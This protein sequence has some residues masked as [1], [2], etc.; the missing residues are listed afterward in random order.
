MRLLSLSVSRSVLLSNIMI[1]I[2]SRWSSPWYC[3]HLKLDVSSS[4]VEIDNRISNDRRTRVVALDSYN[5][6]RSSN[7][8][9]LI[10]FDYRST[11]RLTWIRSISSYEQFVRLLFTHVIDKIL[12]K[13][14]FARN[15]PYRLLF[16]TSLFIQGHAITYFHR[17]MLLRFALSTCVCVCVCSVRHD[18]PSRY[19]RTSTSA[20]RTSN[21]IDEA[22]HRN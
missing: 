10:L 17:A 4:T 12:V 21:R 14:S 9:E 2:V 22:I 20:I 5:E 13:Y 15:N 1:I 8:T 7:W 18:R 11:S 3:Q 6:T 19:V 16:G